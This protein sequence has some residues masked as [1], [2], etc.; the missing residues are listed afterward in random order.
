MRPCAPRPQRTR[1]IAGI[2]G[3]PRA[4]TAEPHRAQLEG[5]RQPGIGFIAHREK[6][7]VQAEKLG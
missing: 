6:S 7:E 3:L 1:A 5:H 4:R 2:A